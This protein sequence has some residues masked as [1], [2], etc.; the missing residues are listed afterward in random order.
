MRR[1]ERLLGERGKLEWRFIG[2]SDVGA[3]EVHR[4]LELE[5]MGWKGDEGT[6][7]LSNPAEARF[8]E[9]MIATLGHPSVFV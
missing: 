8:F 4:F 2:G 1:R 6:S 9:E 5:H 7:L 3:R